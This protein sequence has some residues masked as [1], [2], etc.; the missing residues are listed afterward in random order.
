MSIRVR[1][2]ATA[3]AEAVADLFASYM[4]EA[5]GQPNAMTAE[6]LRSAEGRLFHLLL[7]LDAYGIPVGFAAWR[8]TYDLH[9]A[10]S[11]GEIPDLFVAPAHRG[12]VAA[13]RLVAAAGK[14]VLAS[15]GK[16]IR[17]EVL[18]GAPSRLARR[19][20]IGFASETVYLSGQGLR[21][22]VALTEASD[23]EVVKGLPSP[24]ASLLP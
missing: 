17:A 5:Y 24:N 1:P 11:G 9:H 8:E 7:A 14:A 18:S 22:V 6:V 12:R 16:F 19:L 15:G 4:A 2:F 23:R 3:D 10:V 21:D 20:T 13:I